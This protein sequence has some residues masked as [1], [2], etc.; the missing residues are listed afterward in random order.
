MKETYTNLK[1]K[2]LLLSN[3]Y[4]L[5]KAFLK[6]WMYSIVLLLSSKYFVCTQNI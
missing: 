1:K 6:L 2:K 3:K 4:I 5:Q